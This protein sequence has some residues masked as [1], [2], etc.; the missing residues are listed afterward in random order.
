MSSLRLRQ[1]IRATGLPLILALIPCLLSSCVSDQA[2]RYYAIERYPAKQMD[3][4]SVLFDNPSQA[5]EVIADFQARGASV[6]YMREQAAKVGADAVI[7]GRYGGYKSR[8]D[9]W[10]GTDKYADTYTR[11]TG[12]AIRFKR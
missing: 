8:G 9:T 4:V 3:Q 10:A 7:V 2:F 5:Y 12:T 6:N 11:I 1:R